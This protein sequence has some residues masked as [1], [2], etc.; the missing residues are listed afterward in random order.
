MT[1]LL[2]CGDDAVKAHKGKEDNGR[3][4]KD[5]VQP[6]WCERLQ[7]CNVAIRQA[8]AKNVQ[9]DHNVGCRDDCIAYKQHSSVYCLVIST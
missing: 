2:C 3:C 6:K 7:V 5:A 1:H 8:G 4:C 9:D